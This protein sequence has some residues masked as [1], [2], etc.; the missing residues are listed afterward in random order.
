MSSAI[1]SAGGGPSSS[2]AAAAHS[3]TPS[4]SSPHAAT[5]AVA[6]GDA[7]SPA[8]QRASAAAAR[9]SAS[10]PDNRSTREV[11]D[12]VDSGMADG[13]WGEWDG[14]GVGAN[15]P[16]NHRPDVALR[17]VFPPIPSGSPR[18]FGACESR[19]SK[20]KPQPRRNAPN[21]F[22]SRKKQ[23]TVRLLHPGLS[24]LAFRPMTTARLEFATNRHGCHQNA[25]KAFA[26]AENTQF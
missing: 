26:S 7:D 5:R 24:H 25:G 16:F 11:I 3:R 12:G 14:D 22:P 18:Y 4:S 9:S 23:R 13:A 17:S 21:R 15:A 8:R 1:C 6:A 20:A 19:G 10:G 2:S